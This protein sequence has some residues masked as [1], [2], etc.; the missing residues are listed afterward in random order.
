MPQYD[1]SRRKFRSRRAL[2]DG[3]DEVVRPSSGRNL[4]SAKRDSSHGSQPEADATLRILPLP[5]PEDHP[6]TG[7]KDRRR[8]P[9]IRRRYPV[10]FRA[11]G[12]TC[13]GFTHN[14][15]PMGLF[16]S[17]GL[18]PQARDFFVAAHQGRRGKELPDAGR[19]RALLQGAAAADAFCSERLL[20]SVPAGPRGVLPASG[21]PVS[22][23][24][25]G[26]RD[27]PALLVRE[28]GLEPSRVS[29]RDPKSRASAG[30]ATLA[31]PGMVGARACGFNG[32]PSR[33]ESLI[34]RS[35]PDFRAA[36]PSGVP[37]SRG[38][39]SRQPASRRRS[40]VPPG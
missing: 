22:R 16:V 4:S 11:A 6:M 23:R 5:S 29:P 1:I 2:G 17:L 7:Q 36:V 40:T 3:A 26:D 38:T 14:L 33:F 32:Y 25:L 27:A 20:R 31:V 35:P 18:L 39:G 37:Y 9:R 12:K 10:E 13:S 30:S 19:G 21:P 8:F 28:E 15:S 24:R 34:A